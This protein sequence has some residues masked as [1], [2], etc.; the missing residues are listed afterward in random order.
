MNRPR[1]TVGLYDSCYEHD[2]C[3]V[4]FIVNINGRSERK[5][6][7]NGL[8]ILKNLTHRGAVGADPKAG[9]GAGILIQLC[10]AFFKD[11]F[12]TEL[13]DAGQFAIGMF[14][15]PT[16]P[17]GQA[18]TK[19][20]VERYVLDEGQTILGW[21]KVPVNNANLGESVLPTEPDI[22]QVAIGCSND[23]TNQDDF[24]RK[25]FVIRKQIERRIYQSDIKGKSDFYISSFSSRMINYKGMLLANQ[26]GEYYPDLL[27][28]N[29]A[30][31]FALVHQ[32]FSP[33]LALLTGTFLQ[34][35][36]V[37][38]SSST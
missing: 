2:A 11:K 10:Y 13:P 3:G 8:Q 28:E 35:N 34:P 20:V 33:K 18:E 9:D 7:A 4:G 23:L 15:M 12:E 22:W 36:I 6:V 32:R 5:I 27:D 19:G 25:L 17:A 29:M 26:V 31:S 21:R 24:E 30:S 1:K 14:F 37:C 16:S 38:P